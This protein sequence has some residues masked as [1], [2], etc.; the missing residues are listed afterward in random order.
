M[1]RTTFWSE[2]AAWAA[3]TVLL[4]SH[5]FLG[6]LFCLQA[7][8]YSRCRSQKGVRLW[9]SLCLF[10]RQTQRA[11]LIAGLSQ[12]RC[13]VPERPRS[14]VCAEPAAIS[15]S[16]RSY[17]QVRRGLSRCNQTHAR[18][19]PPPVGWPSP[20]PIRLSRERRGHSYLPALPARV[21]SAS[22]RSAIE[23]TTCTLSNALS[24]C[25]SRASWA[26]IERKNIPRICWSEACETVSSASRRS[27]PLPC[28]LP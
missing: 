1:L 23:G 24:A 12:T 25:P 7:M 5:C 27:P 13:N 3:L 18:A 19:H 17:L 20:K 26:A 28:L 10:I 15:S 4:S 22:A 6:F 14:S 21:A 8:E 2:S 11:C 16:P 9:L